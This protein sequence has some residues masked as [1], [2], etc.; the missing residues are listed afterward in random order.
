MF[1][2]KTQLEKKTK[3]T[4]VLTHHLIGDQVLYLLFSR[5]TS[6]MRN[7][8]TSLQAVETISVYVRGRNSILISIF[9]E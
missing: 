8:I 4:L 6:T 7:Q 5:P 1:D 9:V 3:N 2:W